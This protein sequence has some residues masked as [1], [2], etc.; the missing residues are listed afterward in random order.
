MFK[1]RSVQ[2]LFG[3]IPPVSILH[4]YLLTTFTRNDVTS[5][6]PSRS[7]SSSTGIR[8]A[9]YEGHTVNEP[10]PSFFYH[11]AVDL[12]APASTS[13][14]IPQKPW[15]AFSSTV[16]AGNRQSHAQTRAQVSQESQL[17]LGEELGVQGPNQTAGQSDPHQAA[18][19]LNSAPAIVQ[20]WRYGSILTQEIEMAPGTQEG[21]SEIMPKR[22]TL[23]NNGISAG[24]SGLATKGRFEPLNSEEE[25]LGR[26][27]VRLYRDGE[28][29]PGLYDKPTIGK[30]SKAGR[31]LQR[32][33]EAEQPAFKDEDCT[34]LCILAVPSY[35]T[36]SD[37]LGFV[38]ERTRDE[39]SHFRMIRTERSNR[40]MVLM[41]FRNG[42]KAREWRIEW[43]GKAFDGIE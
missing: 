8:K 7:L 31:A 40:Y 13:S 22:D 29:T 14:Q 3:P 25:E 34:T 23:L 17:P 2:Q 41:K 32:K 37:F 6:L 4:R 35:L 39:V 20:D 19:S 11:L 26:G 42:K 30:S 27:V 18:A 36:P 12:D 43:N 24:P 33:D 9:K 10:M 5:D 38:G 28:E 15:D 21:S 1:A 16:R